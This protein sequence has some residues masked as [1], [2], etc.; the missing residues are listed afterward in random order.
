MGGSHIIMD[1][2]PKDGCMDCGDWC[3]HLAVVNT[4]DRCDLLTNKPISHWLARSECKKCGIT[5][6][7]NIYPDKPYAP[8][9]DPFSK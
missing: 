3:W 7:W 1:V 5:T 6:I 4:L 8:T 2:A 9:N